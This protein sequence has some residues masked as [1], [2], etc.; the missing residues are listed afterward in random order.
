[1]RI[2]TVARTDVFGGSPELVMVAPGTFSKVFTHEG[3]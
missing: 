3:S 2:G 1:M